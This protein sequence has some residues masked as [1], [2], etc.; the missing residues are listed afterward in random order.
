[1]GALIC[2]QGDNGRLLITPP[3]EMHLLWF[4]VPDFV[5]LKEALKVLPN[6]TFEE[7]KTDNGSFFVIMLNWRKYQVDST[8][9]ERIKRLRCKRRGDKK[10]KEETRFIPPSPAEI[11]AYAKAQNLPLNP[12]AFFDFYS[13][14]GWFVGKN[15][16]RDWRAAARNWARHDSKAQEEKTGVPK[17]M[18]P[19][20]KNSKTTP[21]PTA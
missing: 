4:R 2:Q 5:A 6:V 11:E 7:G 19:D 9:Y 18:Q 21:V 13:S 15:K 16:M 8:V 17:W 14:K 1:M 20:A 12:Q 10:R 3:A